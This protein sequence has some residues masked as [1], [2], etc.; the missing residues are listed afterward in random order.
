VLVEALAD[1]VHVPRPRG[2]R[3]EA[4]VYR[5]DDGYVDAL[6]PFVSEGVDNGEPVLVAVPGAHKLGLLRDALGVDR[7]DRVRFL[8]MTELGRNP[9]HIIP[10]WLDFVAAHGDRPVRGIGE[11]IWA[12][13]RPEELVECQLHEA[14]LNV[15][16]DPHTPFQLWC[17]YDALTLDASVLD[18]AHRTHDDTDGAATAH[19]HGLFNDAL[20]APPE[21]AVT[22]PFRADGL[23]AVREAVRQRAMDDDVRY[24][25]MDDLV[26]AV[27]EIATNSVV[28]GGGRGELRMWSTTDAFVVEITDGGRIAD[29]VAGRLP[30]DLARI[31]GRGVWLAHR[32][33]DLVQVRS[34]T[35]G[36]T[37]RISTWR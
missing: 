2:Y 30:P 29:P 25:R 3:H 37:V 32:M 33:C 6:V 17:P 16:V 7:A 21:R 11:P 18:E 26:L 34:N 28:H 13:R 9:A 12:G 31:G 4:V 10:A 14:L 22:L 23:R 1:V 20:P 35:R 8:D 27:H 5:G 19:L 15:V 24:E 36:T